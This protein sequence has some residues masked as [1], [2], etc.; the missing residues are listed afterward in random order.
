MQLCLPIYQLNIIY[1]KEKFYFITILL[2]TI[3]CEGTDVGLFPQPKKGRN[4][5][6]YIHIH[7]GYRCGPVR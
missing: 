1:K 3:V 2:R 5:G 4:I 6:Q 7:T